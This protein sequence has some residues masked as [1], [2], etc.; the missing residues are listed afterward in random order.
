MITVEHW[1]GD[2]GTEKRRIRLYEESKARGKSGPRTQ[3]N[4][5][6]VW[7]DTMKDERQEYLNRWRRYENR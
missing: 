4:S 7:I 1:T 6:Q 3:R 5:S 2:Y